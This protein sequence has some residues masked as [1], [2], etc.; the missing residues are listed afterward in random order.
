MLLILL[1]PAPRRA[2]CKHLMKEEREEDGRIK[3]RE[4]GWKKRERE[5]RQRKKEERNQVLTQFLKSVTDNKSLN[6]FS[7]KFPQISK[8][9][10]ILLL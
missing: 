9:E 3:V 4:E 2:P 8:E 6:P 5:G 7:L 1:S 10:V